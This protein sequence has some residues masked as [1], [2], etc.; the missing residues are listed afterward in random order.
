MR[1][2]PLNCTG[3]FWILPDIFWL[4]MMGTID[5][6]FLS[7][8]F[9]LF[10][11]WHCFS[12]I[13]S[14]GQ[15]LL[16]ILSLFEPLLIRSTTATTQHDLPDSVLGTC[17]TPFFKPQCV[18]GVFIKAE[19]LLT[20]LHFTFR[21]INR[22]SPGGLGTDHRAPDAGVLLGSRTV[23]GLSAQVCLCRVH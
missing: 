5:F 4:W 7:P 20:H 15:L 22:Q 1:K 3:E 2:P 8:S 23:S 9:F 19:V 18:P 13:S 16:L 21:M 6:W 14:F 12:G 17:H 11:C 10:V